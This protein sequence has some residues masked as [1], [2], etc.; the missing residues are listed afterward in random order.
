MKIIEIVISPKGETTLQTRGYTGAACKN[1]TKALEE[2]LG[3]KSQEK[4]T[5][6]YYTQQSES[7]QI[8]Q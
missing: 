6:E 7:Q 8:R 3:I 4:L 5:A 2:S 1:A